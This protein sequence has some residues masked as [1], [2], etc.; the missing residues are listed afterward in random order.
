MVHSYTCLESVY[1]LSRW[2]CSCV[3]FQAR[4]CLVFTGV[5]IAH[6][7]CG[8]VS[9][10]RRYCCRASYGNY[11]SGMTPL[12]LLRHAPQKREDENK[13]SGCCWLLFPREYTGDR[14]SVRAIIAVF[15]SWCPTGAFPYNTITH[16]QNHLRFCWNSWPTQ[17]SDMVGSQPYQEKRMIIAVVH[18]RT[19]DYLLHRDQPIPC[20]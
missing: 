18:S 16:A 20:I 10:E 15:L 1:F 8:V 2:R 3:M 13:W 4:T 9:L 17:T 11:D 14:I 12:C 5:S 6:F 7:F 19:V